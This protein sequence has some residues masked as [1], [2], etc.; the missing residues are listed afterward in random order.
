M[1][2]KLGRWARK[3]QAQKARAV[4]KDSYRKTARLRLQKM[5]KAGL[6]SKRS[7]DKNNADTRDKIYSRS[8][9]V[10]YKNQFRY[11]ADWLTEYHSEAETIEDARH[12]VD[13]YLQRLIDSNKSAY[14]IS[15]AKA[16]L[17]K[18]FQVEATQ[19]IA[20]PPRIRQNIVRSRADDVK[21]GK[22]ISDETERVLARFTSATGLRR[23]EMKQI[24]A[25]DL[26]FKNGKPY[27]R[28]DKGTKGGKVRNAE[29]VGI[30]PEET[31]AIVKWIESKSGR[32]FPSLHSNYDNHSYRAVYASRL[33]QKYAR[34]VKDIPKY[35]RYVMRKDRAGKVLDRVAMLCVS[36]NLGH[37]RIDVVAQSYLYK[38]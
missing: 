21:G 34:K 3:R 35:E 29:I 7:K 18:V 13:E 38:I 32:L 16:A 12:F 2:E 17:A 1:A 22:H 4:K 31:K 14:S 8:T 28:V 10:T 27:L 26:F 15:T 24:E 9:F 20:T 5:L 37:N 36:K 6:G 33:Y 25:E 19:F 11:F 23:A 30:S